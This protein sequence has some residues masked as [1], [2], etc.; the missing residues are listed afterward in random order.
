[1][2]E[3]TDDLTGLFCRLARLNEDSDDFVAMRYLVRA[4]RDRYHA[5][6]VSEARLQPKPDGREREAFS[7]LLLDADTRFEHRRFRHLIEETDILAS[8]AGARTIA[9]SVAD[10]SESAVGVVIDEALA[11]RRA[12]N[13]AAVAIRGI[14]RLLRSPAMPL[15]QS[16]TQT[17]VPQGARRGNPAYAELVTRK[18][19]EKVLSAFGTSFRAAIESGV[20]QGRPGEDVETTLARWTRSLRPAFNRFLAGIRE[21]E[22]RQR[23]ADVVESVVDDDFQAVMAVVREKIRNGLIEARAKISNSSDRG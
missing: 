21:E 23:L 13:G 3:L 22:E 16:P 19:A 8:P 5:H 6:F 15:E 20:M 17:S 7:G 18:V 11:V 14:G 12:A 4:W 1:M 9:D 10:V 2:A